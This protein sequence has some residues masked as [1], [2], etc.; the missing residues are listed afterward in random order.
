MN[1]WSGLLES[2]WTGQVTAGPLLV[3]AADSI[4]MA[5]TACVFEKRLFG[6]LFKVITKV[7]FFKIK[8]GIIGPNFRE[9]KRSRRASPR[10]RC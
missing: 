8:M 6:R 3:L 7:S 4:L 10:W 2:H 5:V 1:T 9:F